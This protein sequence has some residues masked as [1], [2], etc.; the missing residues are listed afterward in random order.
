[1]VFSNMSL[2]AFLSVAHSFQ[3]LTF[4]TF[5]LS[6]TLS[7]HLNLGFPS[8]RLPIGF[9]SDVIFAVLEYGPTI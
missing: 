1:M 5:S 7:N 2:Q 6:H 9:Q 4:S 8:G 3:F